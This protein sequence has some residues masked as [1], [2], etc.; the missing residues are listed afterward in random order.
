MDKCP[1]TWNKQKALPETYDL[2]LPSE[3]TLIGTE[4]RD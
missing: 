2:Y 4:I 3:A 1:S